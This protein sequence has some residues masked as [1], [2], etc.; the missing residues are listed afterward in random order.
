[1]QTLS[2]W[3]KDTGLAGLRE[4]AAGQAPPKEQ[5]A[6]TELWADVAAL[7]KPFIVK[8][9]IIKAGIRDRA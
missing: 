8:V 7:L 3:Q 1:M 6:F 2:H 9:E 5:K 4:T